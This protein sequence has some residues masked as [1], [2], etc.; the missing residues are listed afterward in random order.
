MFKYFSYKLPYNSDLLELSLSD[1]AGKDLKDNVMSF[2]YSALYL[3]TRTR[4]DIL[5]F[6]V[7]T[8][9]AMVSQPPVEIV[10]HLD[11]LFGYLNSTRGKD[12]MFR[13]TDT[14]LIRMAD[15]ACAVHKDGKFHT[16][17]VITMGGSLV[18]VKSAEQKL[19]V[20]SS[21]EV[22]LEA[23]TS[24]L[25]KAQPMR[26]LLEELRLLRDPAIV[27]QDDQSTLAIAKAGE[28]FAGNSKRF[29]VKY[30]AVSEQYANGKIK[31]EH[32]GIKSMVADVQ[33]WWRI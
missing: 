19:I 6:T 22:E 13:D 2:V 15:A 27:M 32:R 12:L 25:K 18:L 20:L 4:S 29:R 9:A 1:G 10:K 28:G 24:M 23:T 11:R 26:K 30:H 7:V 14:N 33:A 5:F 17:T 16:G 31:F 8:L 21:T 3:A